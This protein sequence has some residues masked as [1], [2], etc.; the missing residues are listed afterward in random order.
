MSALR[1]VALA[2]ALTGA[3]MQAGEAAPDVPVP[4]TCTAAVNQQLLTLVTSGSPDEVDNVMVCGTATRA[5]YFQSSHGAA[6]SHHV[7]SVAAPVAT[8]GTLL[9]QIVTN[10]SLDGIVTA[11]TGDRVFALGQ[12]YQ[13]TERQ[14]PYVA[15]V[16]DTHCATHAGADNGWV[17]IDG[18]RW[19]KGTCPP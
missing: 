3:T 12:F 10:D 5:T 16:H 7:T 13:T 15:G 2:I 14:R 6:G 1:N 17:V 19:P 8:G 18:N 4:T 9:V 11:Q